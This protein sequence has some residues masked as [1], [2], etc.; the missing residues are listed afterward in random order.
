MVGD[1]EYD[2]M[3]GKNAGTKT[4]GVTYGNGSR[5]SLSEADWI[6]DDFGKLLEICLISS[7]S[8]S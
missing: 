1:T 6:I 7:G 4:C 5:E 2:I 3:M 8:R